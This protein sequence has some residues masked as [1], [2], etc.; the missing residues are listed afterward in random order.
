MQQVSPAPRERPG[1]RP[2]TLGGVIDVR[3]HNAYTVGK[4]AVTRHDVGIE[5]RVA[6]HIKPQPNGCWYWDGNGDQYAMSTVGLVHRWM[7]EVFKGRISE[8]HDVHHHC[9]HPGC[10]NPEHL[11][12]L[13]HSDH[14]RWHR[15]LL[16]THL[17]L[18]PGR[19]QM[20]DVPN[21]EQPEDDEADVEVEVPEGDT[22]DE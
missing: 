17:H 8:G 3:K 21:D 14:M 11:E 2:T 5:E 9:E 20:S 7:Y 22:D 15:G 10:V 19:H 13:T 18:H 6:R 12:A 1:L 4:Y 16:I